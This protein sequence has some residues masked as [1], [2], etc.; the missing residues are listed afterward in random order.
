MTRRSSRFC[1]PVP[2][3]DSDW[4]TFACS[5]VK[6]MLRCQFVPHNMTGTMYTRRGVDCYWFC[7]C[8]QLNHFSAFNLSK[9]ILYIWNTYIVIY[10]GILYSEAFSASPY[11]NVYVSK[12]LLTGNQTRGVSGA[13]GDRS[14]PSLL[15]TMHEGG[16]CHLAL[17][18]G[19]VNWRQWGFAPSSELTIW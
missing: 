9:D 16:N 11:M 7:S 14:A 17:S 10:Y 4:L 8:I 19:P 15:L 12:Q 1:W 2:G 3:C 6:I 5:N 18:P 13:K